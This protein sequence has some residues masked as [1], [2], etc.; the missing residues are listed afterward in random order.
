MVVQKIKTLYNAPEEIDTHKIIYNIDDN[1]E[2]T[3]F[4]GEIFPRKHFTIL[5]SRAGTGK[6]WAV[7]ETISNLTN[8][9]HLKLFNGK[10]YQAYQTLYFAGEAGVQMVLERCNIMAQKPDKNRFKIV[11]NMDLMRKNNAPD[12]DTQ[13]GTLV[14]S[15]II[16]AEKPDFVIFDTLMSFRSNDE[17]SS[18]ETKMALSRIQ[19]LAEKFDCAILLTHHLRK[20]DKRNEKQD[21]DQDEIIGTSALV[22]TAALCYIL[23]NSA[24]PNIRKLTCVKTWWKCPDATFYKMV[25]TGEGTIDFAECDDCDSMTSQ[26]QRVEKR[27]MELEGLNAGSVF[28]IIPLSIANQLGINKSYIYEI[29][30]SFGYTKSKVGG[31][32][33]E[34][35]L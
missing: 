14:I 21:I 2:P 11:S 13:E 23:T 16:E 35:K 12:F 33:W 19:Y 26:R 20:R 5:A 29:I 22:R 7:L 4:V 32:I 8:A 24:V 6:T 18:K 30:S 17:N 25:D 34:K 27:L 3:N 10:N 28:R 9:R 31:G 15:K 1:V